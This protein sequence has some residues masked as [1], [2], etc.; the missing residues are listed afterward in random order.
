MKQL[1][2]RYHLKIEMDS[3]VTHHQFTLRCFPISDARQH[4]SRVEYDI[5]PA[6]FLR[7][8]RDS[9]GNALIYG[10]CRE[11]QTSFEVYVRGQAAVDSAQSVPSENPVRDQLFQYPTA[12]T[13]ADASLCAF[14]DSLDLRGDAL[15]Q[16]ERVMTAVHAALQYTPGVTTVATT[17]REAF[18]SGRGVC[19][20]YAH[21]MLAILR[22]RGIPCRYAVGMLLGEGKSHAW[23]EVLHQN[24]WYSFDPTHSC[25]AGEDYIKLS[26]GRDYLDCTINRGVFRGTANQMTEISVVV[27]EM[28]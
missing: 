2:F 14:A 6:D 27:E 16:A 3:P 11:A 4:I 8:S 17:A 25:R 18:A 10:G 22:S 5:S 20:D 24:R 23:V 19:Q 12:L 21:V 9:W 15:A 1:S 26:H 13:K 7:E 28:E